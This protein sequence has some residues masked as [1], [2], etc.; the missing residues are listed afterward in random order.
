[1]YVNLVNCLNTSNPS[2]ISAIPTCLQKVRELGSFVF[3]DFSS[4]FRFFF[5][6]SNRLLHP[7][8][9]IKWISI[10]CITVLCLVHCDFC[11][12]LF[13]LGHYVFV[14]NAA[15]HIHSFIN[16]GP[17][18]LDYPSVKF[19]DIYMCVTVD[20]KG[21]EKFTFIPPEIGIIFN[22]F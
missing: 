18:H 5:K 6:K 2:L 19:S 4:E 7:T 10:N 1:M 8:S 13:F 11:R 12:T 9:S 21:E 22:C 3:L 20:P 17:G 15:I 14:Q 16:W